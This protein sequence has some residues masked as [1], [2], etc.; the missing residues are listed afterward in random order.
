SLSVNEARKKLIVNLSPEI[1]YEFSEIPITCRCGTDCVIKI[2]K[3]Q[4]FL[5]YGDSKWKSEVHKCIDN[6]EIIPTE[7]KQNF[8]YFVDWLGDWACTR[9]VG[10]GT[11]LPWDKTWLIEPLSDSTIYMAYYTMANHLRKIDPEKLNDEFF[12]KIFYGSDESESDETIKKIRDEFNYWYPGDFRLSAKDLI[13]NHLCFHI[14][15]H[16]ALFPE[17]KWPKGFAVFGMGL[18]EGNKMSSSKGNV[19]L[20]DD[21]ISEYG[22]DAVRLFLMS[23][24]EPWQDFDWQEKLV[25]NT[26]RKLKQFYDMTSFIIGL[27]DKDNDACNE[28]DIDRWLISKLQNTIKETTNALENFQ[29]RKALQYSFFETIND[30]NWYNRRCDANPKILKQFADQWIRLLAPFTPFTS[31]E[32]WAT[33]SLATFPPFDSA[34]R[35]IPLRSIE[36]SLCATLHRRLALCDRMTRKWELEGNEGFISLAKYPVFDENKINKKV[37]VEEDMLKELMENLRNILSL[38]KQTPEKIYFYLAPEWM[39]KLYAAIGEGKQMKDVMKDPEM[40]PHGAEIGKI[41]KRTFKSNIP[42]IVMGLD[43]EYEYLSSVC[44]FLEKEFKCKFDVQKVISH[45]PEGKAGYAKPMKPGIF[46]E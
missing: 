44:E 3:D 8:R 33:L 41:M 37:E 19:V 24:A 1:F 22:S 46:V 31:E 5:K 45:D 6:M 29:T 16:T 21:A 2:L 30:L 4:W 10:L 14:F 25:K 9:R 18:L 35:S 40:R 32:L 27:D 42:G 34:I 38:T 43:E 23:N 36:G 13:G 7:L 15:H 28:R 39:R 12:N 17:D 11:K 26:A 20:L